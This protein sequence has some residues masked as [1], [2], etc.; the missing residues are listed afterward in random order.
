LVDL[1]VIPNPQPGTDLTFVVRE[2]SVA[3]RAWLEAR[4][5]DDGEGRG[6]TETLEVRT[7][8][9]QRKRQEERGGRSS[10]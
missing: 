5:V 7:S 6:A 8:G 1:E 3:A 2:A 10:P 4:T 9:S